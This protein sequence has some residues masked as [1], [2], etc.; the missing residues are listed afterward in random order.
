MLPKV[1]G[2]AG[3]GAL[4]RA[5][6]PGFTSRPPET[7]LL[8]ERL[9]HRPVEP[10]RDEGT[11]AAPD[12]VGNEATVERAVAKARHYERSYDDDIS[13]EEERWDLLVGTA[14]RLDR[15][16]SIVGHGHFNRL[17]FQDILDFARSYTDIGAFEAD[18]LELMEELFDVDAKRYGFL[19]EKPID[20]LEGA[21]PERDLKRI[22]GTGHWLLRGPSLEKYE[23]IRRD[24][25]DRVLLTSGVRG[26]AK[27]YHLFLTKA[28]DTQ[29]NLSQAARSLAPPGYSFHAVG[30][31]DIGKLGLGA[32]NFTDRF[33][34]TDEFKKLVD[35]G[36]VDIRYPEEN[37]F[38]VR[39]EPWHIKIG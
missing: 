19:G 3:L 28:V 6:S 13:I 36:Y 1:A 34:E 4:L 8:D 17:G 35:L 22:P 15:T 29:G 16:Q 21:L 9:A 10:L 12:D 39:H 18:E 11:T 30:D 27:Q 24:L 7:P 38:G 26:L 31:F 23:Q 25:G 37:P 32:D 33:A 5:G 20:D 2:A 14:A